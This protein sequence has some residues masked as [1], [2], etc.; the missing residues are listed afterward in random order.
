VIPVPCRV[1]LDQVT[2]A[3]TSGDV[4]ALISLYDEDALICGAA[5]PD[6]VMSRDELFMRSDM[7]KRTHLVGPI[8]VIP[9]DQTAGLVRA[10]ARS[11][12]N[13]RYQPAAERIWLLTFKGGLV[14]RQRVFGSRAEAADLYARYGVELGMAPAATATAA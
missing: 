1:L 12:T 8:D 3:Y 10:I 11:A 2:E 13:G 5:E 7:V 6:T 4:P 9:I 14:Y